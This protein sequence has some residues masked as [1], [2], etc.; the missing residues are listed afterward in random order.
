M[1]M[2]ILLSCR[3]EEKYKNRGGK[4]EGNNIVQILLMIDAILYNV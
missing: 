2:N 1:N 4:K 3:E